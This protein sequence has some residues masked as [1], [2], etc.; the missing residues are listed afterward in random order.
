[1]ATPHGVDPAGW[2]EQQL[3]TASPDALRRWSPAL[4]MR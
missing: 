1:M 2:L 3:T 4:P